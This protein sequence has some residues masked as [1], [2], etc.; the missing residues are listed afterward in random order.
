VGWDVRSFDTFGSAE[1]AIGR[2]SRLTRD[3]SVILLHD[4]GSS[5]QRIVKIVSI[6]IRDL[7]AKGFEFERL[8]RLMDPAHVSSAGPV[9]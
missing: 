5:P 4:G 7:R 1:K 2:I 9:V 3:G 8:D 6:A